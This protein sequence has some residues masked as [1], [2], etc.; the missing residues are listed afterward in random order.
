MVNYGTIFNDNSQIKLRDLEVYRPMCYLANN[1]VRKC[2]IDTTLN[3]ITMSFQFGLAINT[4]YHILFSV[5]DPRNP[6]VHGFFPTQAIS[7]IVMSYVLSGSST[8]YYT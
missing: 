2:T 8:V 1:R 7:D 3:V 5:V 6:D 4:N